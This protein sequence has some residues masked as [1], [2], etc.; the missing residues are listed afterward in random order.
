MK[1]IN[2]ASDLNY[3]VIVG[4]NLW[5]NLET[6][7]SKYS[8]VVVFSA[9]AMITVAKRIQKLVSSSTKVSYFELPDGEIAKSIDT[10]SACWNFLAESKI[11]RS[12]LI[13]GIG[14]GSVTDL[15]GFVAATWLRGVDVVL[16][17]TTVLGMVDASV[18]G[19]CGINSSFGKNLIGSFNDP[20]AVYCDFDFLS[21]LDKAEIR[22]GFAEIIKCGFIADPD[23]LEIVEKVGSTILDTNSDAFF[24]VASK[25]IEVKATVVSNDKFE[26]SLAGVGRAALNYGHTLGHAIEKFSNY[27]WRHG[28]AISIGMVFAANLSFELGMI[29]SQLRDRHHDILNLVGLPRSFAAATLQDLIPIMA[30]DKKATIDSLRF[31]VLE[32][33]AKPVFI[34]NPSP[35]SL[36][37]AFKRLEQE[38]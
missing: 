37:S 28:E 27:R 16:V 4:S 10:A 22:S 1:G 9:P 3:P 36:A 30:L 17:P 19:K 26:K 33:L 21:T 31:V 32:D 2:I 25:A 5:D 12:D 23:I 13:I 29:T 14:G 34:T 35:S 8:N 6:Q 15:V 20:V 7:I 18:G 24:Q 38:G 11:S